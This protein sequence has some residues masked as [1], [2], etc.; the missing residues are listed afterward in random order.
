MA[1]QTG[2]SPTTVRRIWTPFAYRRIAPRHSSFQATFCSLIR[3]VT[4]WGF[5]YRRR[6]YQESCV[7]G[8]SRTAGCEAAAGKSN[9]R[10]G[11]SK[12]TV[13][14]ETSKTDIKVLRDGKAALIP[15]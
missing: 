8:H 6:D 13:L 10:N 7:C 9:H 14:T 11:Y 1:T 3:C 4:S 15:R 2:F 5:I 12:T